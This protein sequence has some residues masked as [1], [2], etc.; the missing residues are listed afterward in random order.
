MTDE[1]STDRSKTSLGPPMA[2]LGAGTAVLV[3]SEFLPASA[4]PTIADD[5]GV[6]IGTAGLA[7]AFTAV[8]GALSA[9]TIPVLF[10]R[11]DRRRVLIAL[12]VI[13]A[14]ADLTVGVAPDFPLLLLGRVLLG[15]AIAG[16]WAFA[17]GA[18][19]HAA[20]ARASLVSTVLALGVSVATVIGVP[21]GALVVD[22]VGW[23]RAFIAVAVLCALAATGVALALPPVP[24]HPGAGLEM[25][26]AALSNRLVRIGIVLTVL[27]VF[28]NFVA[29]PY[30][31]LAIERVD[32]GA[33][34]ALLLAWGIGGMVGNL[35]AGALAVRLRALTFGAPLVL[36]VGL[37]LTATSST[38]AVVSVAVAVWGLGFN[39][40]P[41]AVQLWFARVES[42]HAES[43]VALSVMAFQVAITVGAAAGG[44]LVDADGIRSV[45]LLSALSAFLSATGFGLVRLPVAGRG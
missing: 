21:L 37:L 34:T 5:I 32:A 14:V 45:L 38:T 27:A 6:R 29:Y 9:P 7:V 42:K 23:R 40:V 43:A 25:M 16:F 36:A 19:V 3:A 4:L 11:A 10:P 15:V 39:M 8:A 33:A 24:A 12:L 22:D 44:A 31:R 28:G 18:G 17:F 35:A 20:P 13:G 26:R 1:T 2:A 30:I 41:V